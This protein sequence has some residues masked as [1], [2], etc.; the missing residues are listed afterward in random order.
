MAQ[1]GI[2]GLGKVQYCVHSQEEPWPA[3]DPDWTKAA[4]KDATVLPPPA[5]WGGGLP[6]GK[7]PAN[8]SQFDPAK[9][10]PL[11]WP[12]PYTI[13]HWAALP[14]P[15]RARCSGQALTPSTA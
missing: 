13:V 11:Q 14:S 10:A 12:M 9:G 3:D 4:W 1:I 6:G 8:T 7:L 2:S 15:C 5:D